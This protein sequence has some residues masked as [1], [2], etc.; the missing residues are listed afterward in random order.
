MHH[1]HRPDEAGEAGGSGEIEQKQVVK[2]HEQKNNFGGNIAVFT[3]LH[4]TQTF[5]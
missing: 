2:R 1:L 4:A 3:G 5:P